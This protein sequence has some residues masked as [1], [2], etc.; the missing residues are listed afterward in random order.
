[1]NSLLAVDIG[2]GT[3]DVL[4]YHPESE[5]ENNIKMILPSQ[6]QIVAKRIREC[7]Q[8]GSDIFLS[9]YLMGG[10]ASS[11]AIKE[12]LSYGYRVYA[13]EEA[14][15]TLKDNL[16]K[17]KEIGVEIVESPPQNCD[18]IELKD[19]DISGLKEAL[20]L[21]E[22]ELPADY[23]LAVQ[24]HGFAPDSSNRLFRFGHWE[25]F[26]KSGGYLADLIYDENSVPDYFTRMH[27]VMEAVQT[28][29]VRSG[30]KVWITDT[31]AAA[32]LGAL[33]DNNVNREVT[34]NNGMIVNIGNQHT[35]A[36]LVVGQRVLG[37]FEHHTKK[38]TEEKLQHHLDRF[39]LG[40]LSNE[41]V[42][43][44]KGHGCMRVPEADEHKFNFIAVTGPR[45]N[46]GKNLGY[47]AIPHGDMMLSGAFGLVRGV[48]NYVYRKDNLNVRK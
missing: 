34:Q 26:L 35:I 19:I 4:V 6:T 45:R 17:V 23:A 47:M 10:G 21:F 14:A 7:T 31:G 12:H 1:M 30:H 42:L 22:E 15:L 13:T 36:F 33:E 32:I 39:V 37:V 16:N 44:D 25:K 18:Q 28:Q 2:S 40:E 3:Q 43:E 24:D 8:M 38:L 27:A 29:S 48:K 11:K 9:G 5:M 20:A 41:E 46:L